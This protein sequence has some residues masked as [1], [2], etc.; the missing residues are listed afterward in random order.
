[1]GIYVIKRAKCRF[2]EL[3]SEKL[4]RGERAMVKSS[5]KEEEK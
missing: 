4:D 2:S 5:S 1:L 3:S